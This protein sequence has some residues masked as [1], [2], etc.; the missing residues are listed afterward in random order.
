[1]NY[2]D[3]V[4]VPAILQLVFFAVLVGIARGAGA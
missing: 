3:L 2:I 4:A 1:M